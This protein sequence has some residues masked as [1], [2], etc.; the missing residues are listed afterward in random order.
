MFFS[1]FPMKATIQTQGRQFVVQE[2][3]VLFVTRLP[4][5]EAGQEVEIKEVLAVG[6]GASA[7]IGT[8]FVEGASVK[9]RVLQNKKDRK[10]VIF[11]KKR[12]KGFRRRTGHRQPISVIRVESIVA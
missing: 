6:E 10:V 9:V 3:D 1:F 7:R 11:K 2:N 4:E 12:R 8:P 5:T